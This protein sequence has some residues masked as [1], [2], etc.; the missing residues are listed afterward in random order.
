MLLQV[1]FKG[2]SQCCKH[3]STTIIKA[4]V[5]EFYNAEI[6]NK[7]KNQSLQRIQI[8]FMCQETGKN[9]F[10]KGRSTL[11]HFSPLP[12]PTQGLQFCTSSGQCRRAV[13]CHGRVFSVGWLQPQTLAA[14]PKKR[15]LRQQCAGILTQCPSTRCWA[16]SARKTA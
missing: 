10:L 7:T 15:W 13:P 9:N 6:R 5:V 11:F 1:K 3:R 16:T 14:P 2:S 8:L 4:I 12:P